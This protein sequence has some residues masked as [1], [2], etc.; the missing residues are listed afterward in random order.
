VAVNVEHYPIDRPGL[1]IVPVTAGFV[2][3]PMNYGW[4]DYGA[5][6]GVFALMELLEQLRVP[7]TAPVHAEACTRYPQIIERG[8]GLGWRWMAHGT[9]NAALHADLEIDAERAALRSCVE[10]I[11]SATGARPEGWLG[12]AL[13]ET[14]NTPGLLA[15]LGL[16][17]V[18]DWCNDDR[19][20]L[21]SEPNERIVSVPYSVELN[22]VTLLL[23]K[24]W[25]AQ[26][27]AEALI[28]QFEALR[29]SGRRSGV[30]MSIPLHP[31]LVGV[32]FRLAA[33]KSVLAHIAGSGD[34]WLTTGD[35]IAEHYLAHHA[36]G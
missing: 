29:E 21:L 19:P 22:D 9:D 2:P 27:Y 31:F 13:T 10:T 32:P 8:V 6:V 12:P 20:Y 11:A 36:G 24:G 25:T 3:D 17:Y 14:F 34:A 5:R 33:L 18:C 1:S 30:V 23:A 35:A 28:N 26:Q 16:S 15:E 7:V 4:R